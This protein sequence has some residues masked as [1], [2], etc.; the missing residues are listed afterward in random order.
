ML[1]FEKMTM[2]NLERWDSAKLQPRR[3]TI[4]RNR[5]ELRGAPTL[6]PIALLS[7]KFTNIAGNGPKKYAKN[8]LKS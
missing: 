2:Q 1:F 6:S 3:E 8:R 7:K 5:S 4:G